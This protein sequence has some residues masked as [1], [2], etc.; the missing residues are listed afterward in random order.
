MRNATIINSKNIRERR[1]HIQLMGTV[2]NII[3]KVT[4]LSRI[5]TNGNVLRTYM[6]S[7]A[8]I[9]INSEQITEIT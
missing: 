2:A 7:I 4:N 1:I 9:G 8:C 5:G 6:M 3:E